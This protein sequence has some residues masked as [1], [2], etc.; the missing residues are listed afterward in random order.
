MSKSMRLWQEFVS[1]KLWEFR[2]KNWNPGILEPLTFKL[3]IMNF[4]NQ[5][6]DYFVME[7]QRA[8]GMAI[9]CQSSFS[10][11]DSAL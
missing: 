9:Q 4:P 11:S 5:I 6:K 8:T 7:S 2:K 1:F 3:Q 10:D